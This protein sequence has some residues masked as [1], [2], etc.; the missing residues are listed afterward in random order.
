VHPINR[1]TRIN[2]DLSRRAQ[3]IRRPGSQ[4]ERA[5]GVSVQPGGSFAGQAVAIQINGL[6]PGELVNVQVSSTDADGVPWQASAAYRA[7]PGGNVDLSTPAAISGS[8]RGV[9][10]MGLIWSMH[11]LQPDPAG[12]YFW[13]GITPLLFTLTVRAHRTQ[14]ASARFQR[15]F[16][17][18]PVAES[19]ESLAADDFVDEFWHPA[20]PVARGPAVLVL[21]GSEGL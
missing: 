1:R 4:P 10:E 5:A 20:V 14:V 12:A 18:G 6:S 16:S 3:T 19:M 17:P 7:D 13:G 11:P 15:S 9:S 21:G 8:Y 2:R